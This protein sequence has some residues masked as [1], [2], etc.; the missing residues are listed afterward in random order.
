MVLMIISAFLI[1]DAIFIG[2]FREA[3]APV[4]GAV[5][6]AVVA[7]ISGIAIYQLTGVNT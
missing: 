3:L 4:N 7:L 6:N 5:V 2:S 1:A